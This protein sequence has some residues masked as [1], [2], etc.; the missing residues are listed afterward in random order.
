MDGGVSAWNATLTASAWV[1][2]GD[3]VQT[4]GQQCEREDKMRGKM[5]SNAGARVMAAFRRHGL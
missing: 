1:S 3:G 5:I 2:D 4:H